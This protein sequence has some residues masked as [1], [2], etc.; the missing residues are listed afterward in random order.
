M[1]VFWHQGGLHIQPEGKRESHLLG[2]LLKGLKV[3]RPPEIDGPT[4]TG[5]TSGGQD[6]LDCL[7][8]DHQVL[9]SGVVLQSD[10][11]QTVVP[12]NKLR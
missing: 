10:N 3:E 11:K 8:V 7:V 1:R 12:I 9:P 5:Q 6:L 2:E 4:C